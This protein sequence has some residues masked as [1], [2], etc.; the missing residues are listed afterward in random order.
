MS[1][2]D[3]RGWRRGDDELSQ[4][5]DRNF[6]GWERGRIS[7]GFGSQYDAWSQGAGLRPPEDY[8]GRGPRA[9]RRADERIQEETCERLTDDWS[10][11]ASN[12]T[13]QV[14]DGEVLLSGTV[15]S[16][17]QKRRAEECVESVRGV[18]DVINQLT[19]SRDDADRGSQR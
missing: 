6:E 12:I 13:V 16:R 18:H 17:A 1:H 4:S 7:G 19:V 2:R 11:D 15:A 14:Q 8:R 3:D 9:Y 5:S 10:V